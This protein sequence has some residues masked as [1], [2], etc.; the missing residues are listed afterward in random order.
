MNQYLITGLPRTRSAWLANLLTWG[1][2]YCHHEASLSCRS[3][4]DLAAKLD[5]GGVPSGTTHAGN[6]DPSMPMFWRPI[7]DAFPNAKVV[8]IIRDVTEAAEAQCAASMAENIP[9][10]QPDMLDL[11]RRNEAECDAWFQ[12]LKNGQAM[13]IMF[14]DL[15]RIRTIHALW[16]F[17]LP[18]IPFPEQRANALQLLR[19]TQIF[20]KSWAANR[21]ESDLLAPD[22]RYLIEQSLGFQEREALCQ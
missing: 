9:M 17:L 12:A 21:G 10:S 18:D 1:T 22:G 11:C 6:A 16:R 19:V 14:D 15:E 2:S 5:E 7:M 3:I 8:F 20:R 4:D 13:L